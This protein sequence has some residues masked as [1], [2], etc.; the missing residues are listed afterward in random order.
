MQ[1]RIDPDIASHVRKSTQA[2]RRIF[3]RRKSYAEYVNEML[4]SAWEKIEFLKKP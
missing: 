1:V 4:R 3:K 2:H